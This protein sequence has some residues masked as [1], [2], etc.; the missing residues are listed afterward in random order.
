MKVFIVSVITVAVFGGLALIQAAPAAVPTAGQAPL[1][2]VLD[3]LLDVVENV[4]LGNDTVPSD[5]EKGV[6]QLLIGSLE[7]VLALINIPEANT[8]IQ[9]VQELL[10]SLVTILI[11]LLRAL[12]TV[13]PS[14]EA[15]VLTQVIR[16]VVAAIR[17]LL[18]IPGAVQGLPLVPIDLS[19]VT[20]SVQGLTGPVVGIVT[21]L[22][23][24]AGR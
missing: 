7:P 21:G 16:I 20:N 5:A 23:G 6:I 1:E 12:L 2:K 15:A 9:M 10:I 24:G 19:A 3:A 11:K 13:R 22:L 18:A 17:A 4:L 14:G 8:V